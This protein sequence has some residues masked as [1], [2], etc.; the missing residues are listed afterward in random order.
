MDV[1]NDDYR[2]EGIAIWP[3]NKRGISKFNERAAQ[4]NILT[5]D[6][7][8][9]FTQINCREKICYIHSEIPRFNG[10]NTGLFLIRYQYFINSVT[11]VGKT[12]SNLTLYAVQK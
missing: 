3:I 6:K 1:F 8:L 2:T 7:K 10:L 4:V 5:T 12:L 9:H 11:G